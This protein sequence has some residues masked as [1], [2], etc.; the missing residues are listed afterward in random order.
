MEGR[1]VA[2]PPLGSPTV[3]MLSVLPPTLAE[4]YAQP[5]LLFSPHTEAADILQRQNLF[6]LDSWAQSLSTLVI[7]HDPI[8]IRSGA[9]SRLP[10]LKGGA[11]LPACPRDRAMNSERSCSSA[12]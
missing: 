1:L 8:F 5:D 4:L 6:V 12:Q 11:S 9:W 7:C 3:Q 10:L 2:E